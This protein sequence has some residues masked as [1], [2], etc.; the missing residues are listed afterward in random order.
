MRRRGRPELPPEE[1]RSVLLGV[2]VR[3]EER[4]WIRKA[5]DGRGLSMS[6]WAREVLVRAA[7]AVVRRGRGK[8]KP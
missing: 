2:H 7:R 3:P 8:S 4:E 5:A 6:A 1:V